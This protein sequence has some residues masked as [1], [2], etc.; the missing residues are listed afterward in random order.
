MFPYFSWQIPSKW[1]GF[2]MVNYNSL[3]VENGWLEVGRRRSFIFLR[4]KAYFQGRAVKLPGGKDLLDLVFFFSGL[5]THNDLKKK[6][7][8][9]AKGHFFHGKIYDVCRKGMAVG[10]ST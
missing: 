8:A 6:D 1:I 5:S 3:P 9:K 7:L 10:W 2:S 4:S